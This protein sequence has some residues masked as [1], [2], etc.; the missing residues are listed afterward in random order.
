MGKLFPHRILLHYTKRSSELS[1]TNYI[2]LDVSFD[3]LK[4]TFSGD[5]IS[6]IRGC[7]ALKFL[8]AP[9]IDK[10]LL[11]HTPMGTGVP[12]NFNRENL[13]YDTVWLAYGT[14]F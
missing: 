10:A 13:Q 4:W 2:D 9:E 6:A 5:Y 11:A 3:P 7:C 12:K 14:N 1:S 8:H